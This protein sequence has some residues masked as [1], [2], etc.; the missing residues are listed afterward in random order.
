MSSP[1]TWAIMFSAVRERQVTAESSMT[2]GKKEEKILL[3]EFELLLV[4]NLLH[5]L[6][7]LK[8]LKKGSGIIRRI[9]WGL[10]TD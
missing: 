6:L 5:V 2:D 4:F 9:L 10:F 3:T 7:L 8:P 1:S